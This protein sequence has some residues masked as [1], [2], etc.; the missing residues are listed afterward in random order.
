MTDDELVAELRRL[1]DEAATYVSCAQHDDGEWCE[2]CTATSKLATLAA[3]NALRLL[4]LADEAIRLRAENKLQVRQIAD[5]ASRSEDDKD[6]LR[7]EIEK[8]RA[9]RDAAEVAEKKWRDGVTK[10][11]I[12]TN[13]ATQ[14]AMNKLRRP[15]RREGE[16]AVRELLMAC[17]VAGWDAAVAL[18]QGLRPAE[19]ASIVDRVL[20]EHMDEHEQAAQ[21]A[22]TAPG[23]VITSGE[24]IQA[25]VAAA[26]A[27][28]LAEG[29]RVGLVRGLERALRAECEGDLDLLTFK[30]RAE[31]ERLRG[32]K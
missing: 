13:I 9:V 2:F 4:D 24:Q 21:D 25:Q 11:D 27:E 10:M 6:V 14:Y 15:R 8:L 18:K 16:E 32:E 30:I 26:R 31:I 20:A 5:Y 22:D 29:A 1:N 12:K 17:V 19:V 3:N 28:G 7:A 23:L